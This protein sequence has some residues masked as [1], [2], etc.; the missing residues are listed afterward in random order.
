MNAQNHSLTSSAAPLPQLI[1]PRLIDAL[2]KAISS[3]ESRWRTSGFD[4][5]TGTTAI[6][7]AL[8][9]LKA[10]GIEL[11]PKDP[12]ELAEV[13]RHA[14]SLALWMFRRRSKQRYARLKA[15]GISVESLNFATALNVVDE[16]IEREIPVDDEIDATFDYVDMLRAAGLATHK[17]YAMVRRFEGADWEDIQ[18]ELSDCG[19]S[20]NQATL[21]Q[22]FSRLHVWCREVITKELDA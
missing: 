4:D 22:W 8:Q 16:S 6:I 2:Y 15:R 20:V 3:E 1:S 9:H 17:A 5:R 19:H 7:S 13:I 18:D 10:R 21:R 11:D 14:R 12:A